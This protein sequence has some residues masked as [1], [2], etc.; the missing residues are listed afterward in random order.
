LSY[1]VATPRQ[2]LPIVLDLEKRTTS[3]VR[4]R[5]ARSLVIEYETAL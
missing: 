3:A 2:A 4:S 1:R 5:N